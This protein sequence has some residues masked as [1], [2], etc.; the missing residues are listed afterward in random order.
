MADQELQNEQ[1][2]PLV[3]SGYTAANQPE[4]AE[5]ASTAMGRMPANED[6][7]GFGY[8]KSAARCEK[9]PRKNLS[10]SYDYYE[11][12]VYS[13]CLPAWLMLVLRF[14]MGGIC[15]SVFLYITFSQPFVNFVPDNSTDSNS[16]ASDITF[17]DSGND[18]TTKPPTVFKRHFFLCYLTI[19]SYLVITIYFIVAIVNTVT[20]WLCSGGQTSASLGAT[21][22]VQRYSLSASGFKSTDNLMGSR[23]DPDSALAGDSSPRQVGLRL[24]WLLC[25]IAAN[26]A[27]LVTGAYFGVLYPMIQKANPA[28]INPI[29]VLV[30]AF[31]SVFMLTEVLFSGVPVR[32][33]HVIYT[34]LY[35]L[36]YSAFSLL[37]WLP[38]HSNV[39]Y[40]VLLDWNHVGLTIGMMCL[41]LFVGLPVIQLLWWLIYLA[42]CY[43][44][45][46]LLNG[47]HSSSSWSPDGLR[48]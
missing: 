17:L 27:L 1:Q 37:Y 26:A 16:G 36:I 42:R 30:H 12:F 32:L 13:Q 11:Y 28:P 33:V 35:G 22:S 19:W 10:L 41:L 20:L 47:R 23:G 21:L 7:T 29:D 14:I 46:S 24:Q 44:A 2:S 8:L 45:G 18:T 34:A 39:I 6:E 3:A 5:T 9:T 4:G 15:V 43:V 25:G 38:D 31:N 40:P 48:V